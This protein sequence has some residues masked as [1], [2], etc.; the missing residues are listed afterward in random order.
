MN[1]TIISLKS[2]FSENEASQDRLNVGLEK[3]KETAKQIDELNAK[4]A[5]QKVILEEKTQS[6][7]E[8]LREIES[9]TETATA[10]KTEAQAKSI[11]VAAKQKVITKEKVCLGIWNSFY[12]N[13]SASICF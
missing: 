5:I 13:K 7:E 9:S 3:L 11:D 2:H 10:K 1:Q 12:T 6:C 8:L 4:M